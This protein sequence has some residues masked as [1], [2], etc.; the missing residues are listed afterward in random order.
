MGHKIVEAIIED[1]QLKHVEGKLPSGKIKVQLIYDQ[2]E[3][4]DGNE[5]TKILKETSG[6]YSDIDADREARSLRQDWDR[7]LDK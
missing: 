6:I 7:N 4:T 1:G 3:P 5:L 2:E